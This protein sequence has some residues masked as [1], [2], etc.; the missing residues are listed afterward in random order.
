[1]NGNMSVSRADWQTYLC[2]ECGDEVII[3]SPP[4]HGILMGVCCTCRDVRHAD[5]GQKEM[6]E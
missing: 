6:K 5:I 3:P 2:D 1:M 4:V